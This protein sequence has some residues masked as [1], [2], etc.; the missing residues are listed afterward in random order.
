MI[1]DW[2]KDLLNPERHEPQ[3]SPDQP[4]SQIDEP[5]MQTYTPQTADIQIV[6][7]QSTDA[8]TFGWLTTLNG[9]ACHTLEL[10]W[11]NNERR[12]SCIPP[13]RYVALLHNS[14]KFGKTVWLQDV[15]GRSEILIH[16]GNVAGDRSKGLKSDVDGC[17]L[18]GASR[19][20]LYGQPAVLQSRV[21]LN[22]LLKL[23]PGVLSVEIK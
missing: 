19:G 18:V 21:A 15:P 1:C 20:A 6:R 7:E 14:P 23:V 11:R 10:P 3:P 9:F 17:I 2:I 12:I 8:G 13:G 22:Q 16:A 4:S 5:T